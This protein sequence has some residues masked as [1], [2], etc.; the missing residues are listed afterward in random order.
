MFSQTTYQIIQHNYYSVKQYVISHLMEITLV[1]D[2]L[3]KQQNNLC[4]KILRLFQLLV[5]SDT[6]IYE[7]ILNIDK[8]FQFTG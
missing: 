5:Y 3:Q 8:T 4:F 2:T 7:Q 6:Y 1:M